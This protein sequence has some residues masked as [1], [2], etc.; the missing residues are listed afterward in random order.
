MA[1]IN[2]ERKGPSVLPWVIGLV[3]LALLVWALMEMFGADV[4]PSVGFTE[5]DSTSVL[6][7]AINTAPILPTAPTAQ[8]LPG[9]SAVPAVGAPASELSSDTTSTGTASPP[10]TPGR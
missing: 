2:V 4:E 8:P 1:D 10:A 5:T 9:D 6:E 7:P 3:V